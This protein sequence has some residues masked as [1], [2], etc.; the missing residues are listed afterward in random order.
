MSSRKHL[1]NRSEGQAAM[2]TA[3]LAC[4]ALSLAPGEA[5]AEPPQAPTRPVQFALVN[6]V[7]VF[8]EETS[9]TGFRL[10]VF[11]GVN[12]DVTG[13]DLSAIGTHTLGTLRGLQVALANQVDA[14][15]TGVQIGG[16]VNRV[17]GRLRGMQLSGVMAHA[18]DG[19]GVQIA[20]ILAQATK[21]R[22]FQLG[23]VTHAKEMKGLQLGLLNFNENGFLPVFPIFNFGR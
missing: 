15:C 8:G 6:P 17:E 9:V 16:A 12:R 2:A 3:V 7:Q 4:V 10:S 1:W 21:L 23:L 20:P 19:A 11:V 14:D 22:G 5:G 13:L 18:G